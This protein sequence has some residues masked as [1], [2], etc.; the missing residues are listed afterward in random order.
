MPADIQKRLADIELSEPLIAAR[1]HK[2]ANL[3]S[4]FV[5][6]EG[7]GL[8]THSHDLFSGLI[9]FPIAYGNENLEEMF[10]HRRGGVSHHAEVE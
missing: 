3:L 9:T 7:V 2:L 6:V 8:L 5:Q 4:E 1:R 10:L